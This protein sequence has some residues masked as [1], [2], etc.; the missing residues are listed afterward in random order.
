MPLPPPGKKS[1]SLSK[2][3]YNPVFFPRPG[4]NPRALPHLQV[5]S[6]GGLSST[7]PP[8]M[9]LSPSPVCKMLQTV[10]KISS[11]SLSAVPAE[12]VAGKKGLWKEQVSE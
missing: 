5:P 2:L 12:L 7:L 4:P 3:G 10:D 9:C 1:T 6:P 8:L 11:V